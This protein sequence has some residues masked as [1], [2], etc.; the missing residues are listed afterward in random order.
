VNEFAKDVRTEEADFTL[1]DIYNDSDKAILE[2]MKLS[3]N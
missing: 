3:Q 2:R 1:R